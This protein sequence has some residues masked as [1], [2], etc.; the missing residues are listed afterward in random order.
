MSFLG[1][2]AGPLRKVIAA[3]ADEL[4][5]PVLLPCAQNFGGAAALYFS[6]ALRLVWQDSKAKTLTVWHR[7]TGNQFLFPGLRLPVPPARR[8]QLVLPGIIG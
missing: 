6:V 7:E 2:I 4:T 5:V 8:G 1:S 3:Y